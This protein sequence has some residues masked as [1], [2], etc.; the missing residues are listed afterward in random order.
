LANIEVDVAQ[1]EQHIETLAQIGATPQ[2]GVT[3]LSYSSLERDA[4]EYIAKHMRE[5]DL[6]VTVDSA[7][8]T[9]GLLRGSEEKLAPILTGS[10][11]DTVINGGRYDGVV[12]VVGALEAIRALRSAGVTIKHPIGVL[13][14]AGEEGGTR[15]GNGRLGSR[16]KIGRIKPK[17]IRSLKDEKGMTVEDAMKELGLPLEQIPTGV[18]KPGDIAGFLELHIEQGCVLEK[19]GKTVGIVQAIVA[20]D[21]IKIDITGRADHAGGTPMNERKDALLA[22]AE[23]IV[24]LHDIIQTEG[25][26]YTVGN[27]GNIMVKPGSVSTVP[28]RAI[29]LSELRDIDAAI[30][31]EIRDHLL[32]EFDRIAKTRGVQ[33]EVDLFADPDPVLIP[34]LIQ[35]I[36]VDACKAVGTS[37][38]LMPSAGGH[39]ASFMAEIAP[40][41][42]I[43]VPSSNGVSHQPSEYSDLS[44]IAT[45]CRVLAEAL[46]LL[47]RQLDD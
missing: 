2:G 18:W 13:I 46:L 24:K 26:K 6:E 31:N 43:F 19:L 22:G 30:K 41:G 5:A 44:D 16:I 39:D 40:T 12:G 33:M 45:G 15:F 7:G 14:F 21:R 1:L 4:H 9:L 20:A 47:D 36:L 3:R 29:I 35:E 11:L 32:I 37:Y 25:G 27:V 34:G 8:N 23:M 10:H 42:M 17:D 28:D 38:H